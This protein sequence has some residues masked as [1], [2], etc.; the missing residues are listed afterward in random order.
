MT[1]TRL[2]R[3]VWIPV[4]ALA[5]AVFGWRVTTVPL[6]N[7]DEGIYANVNLELF[8]SHDW[9]KLTYFGADFLEKPPLQFWATYPLFGIFGPTELAVRFWSVFAGVATSMLLCW[10]AWQASGRRMTALLAASFFI[11]GRFA[12]VHAFRTGDLDGLLTFFVTLAMYGYWRAGT[13][14]RWMVVWGVSTA[15]AIM[16]KS[17]V[18][19]VPL[20]AVGVDVLIARAWRRIGWANIA[21]GVVTFLLLVM[22]WHIVETVRFGRSFWDSYL[23]LNV[24]ERTT[25]S[26]FT[27]TPWHWYL[28]I[29]RDRFFP[30]SFLFP[31]ALVTVATTLWNNKR[32]LVRPLLIWFGF[33]LAIFSL[34]QTRREW[35]ILP[36]YPAA[37]MLLSMAAESWWR[38]RQ[39]RWFQVVFLLGIAAAFGHL[40]TDTHLRSV[41]VRMPLTSW[42]TQGIWPTLTGQTIFGTIV[43]GALIGVCYTLRRTRWNMWQWMLVKTAG[44]MFLIALSWSGLYIKALPGALPLKTIAT[45]LEP[46]RLQRVPLIGTRL[47]KQPAGYFYL[48]RLDTHFTEY[49]DGTL[50]TL[51]VVITTT[52]TANSPLNTEGRVLAQG[53]GMLLIDLR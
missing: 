25:D 5:I 10:W 2:P 21:W 48:L 23:G 9:T 17:L 28:G 4:L 3:V 22:P 36:L 11:L 40:L 20:V 6:T 19:I 35:Y 8:K 27:S 18:G 29:F 34:I 16:T 12:L 51:P 33:I 13:A 31:L 37:A 32:E 46:E 26:L 44:A 41:L 45:R 39:R 42:L 49:P 24:I 53:G 15:A 52:E 7:W 38:E 43:G 14:P 1:I 50:P 47:K 30:F